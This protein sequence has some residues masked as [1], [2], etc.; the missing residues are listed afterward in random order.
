M[1]LPGLLD[2]LRRLLDEKNSQR[3]L[4]AVASLALHLGIFLFAVVF[5]GR[6]DGLGSSNQ[7]AM[8]MVMIEAPEVDRADGVDLRPIDP[9]AVALLAEQLPEDL[10]A[11][12][13][14]AIETASVEL[15]DGE[16]AP[17]FVPPEPVVAVAA[18]NPEPAEPV[19]ASAEEL[20]A[21]PQRLARL[22]EALHK[23]PQTPLEW[24]ENG[25]KYR[26]KL[27]YERA[28]D[29]TA[30][31]RV[32]AEVSASDHGKVMSTRVMLK[33]L[34]FS[35]FT[36]VVDRWDPMV[37]LHDDVIVG[38]FHSNSQF[39]VL[40][41]SRVGPKF[42]GKVTTA[43]RSFEMASGGRR[44]QAEIFPGG[45]ETRTNRI[46][47]PEALKPFDW[48]SEGEEVR[49]HE[50][51]DDTRIRFFAD[52]SYMWRTHDS[53]GSG[54][55]NAP[56]DQP[57]YFIGAPGVTLYVQGT[58]AGNI[59]I[60]SPQRIVIEDDLIYAHDPRKQADSRDYLGLVSDRFIE[61]AS[62]SVTGPGDLQ[63]HAAI[64][65]GRRFLVRD[66]DYT[67]SATMRVYGSLSAGSL[68]ASEP[69][70]AT[71]IEYDQRFE[72]R[73]PSGFPFTSRYEADAWDGHWTE[74][75]ERMAGETF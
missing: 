17:P 31:E 8:Q 5:G 19:V 18:V 57:I 54:Y 63:I 59:L 49:V 56:T 73:R 50:L 52:G 53:P 7:A 10:V 64:F 22:A 46:E 61:I 66:I 4:A 36:Q 24:Q 25:K 38:R 58:V 69:R 6:Q 65:A 75:P 44:R 60:Y 71:E 47:L 11:P 20:A 45:V 16:V 28:R 40:H 2:E 32:I 67:R 14:P 70:Y 13:L 35:Q 3:A 72:E 41:D 43:A 34:A 15:A 51:G 30:L 55:L 26:A 37:Q 1:A 74:T 21:L 33:R 48:S 9:S 23:A 27:V 62:P 39:I 68:S 12:P 42:L 29:G